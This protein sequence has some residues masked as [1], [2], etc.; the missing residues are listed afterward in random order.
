[1]SLI[2]QFKISEDRII[3]IKITKKFN[4]G[5]I[6]LRQTAEGFNLIMPSLL[7]QKI[8]IDFINKNHSWL[9]RNSFSLPKQQKY[10]DQEQIMFLGDPYIITHHDAHRGVTEIQENKIV[11][12]G[13][14]SN[15]KAKIH[16]F[17]KKELI[18]RTEEVILYHSQ[19]M[20]ISYTS[21]DIRNTRSR[22]GSCSSSGRIM[23]SLRLALCPFDIIEYVIVHEMCHLFE[24]N[25]SKNF[26]KLVK[27]NY[28]TYKEAEDWLKKEGKKLPIL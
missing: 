5:S 2:Y 24:M 27:Q 1:M 13:L 7:P 25:H 9:I 10:T 20:G 11:V 28:P 8:A 3:P 19:T 21:L 12:Y 6:S 26:W 23:L 18:N 16:K 15:I 4:V 22:W 17:L 14:E